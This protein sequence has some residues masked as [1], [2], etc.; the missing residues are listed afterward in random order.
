M[1]GRTDADM[2]ASWPTRP[3][4]TDQRLQDDTDS[5]LI[6]DR[7]NI[8]I[9]DTAEGAVVTFGNAMVIVLEVEEND[10]SATDTLFG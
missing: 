3:E 7:A 2:F 4:R 6:S 1:T 5:L 9:K 10:V 8:D